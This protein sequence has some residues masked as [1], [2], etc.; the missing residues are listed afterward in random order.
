MSLEFFRSVFDMFLSV[1]LSKQGIKSMSL[2]PG[3][4]KLP[5]N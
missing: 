3:M 1:T 4:Y 2:K 5:D